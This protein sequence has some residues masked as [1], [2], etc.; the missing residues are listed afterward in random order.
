MSESALIWYFA[1]GSNMHA[2]TFRGRRGIEPLEARAARAP[3]WR[4]VLDKPPLLPIGESFANL[5]RDPD[6]EAL[7]VAYRIDDAAWQ[8]VCFTEGVAIGNYACVDL[9]CVA[10]GDGVQFLA[11]TLSS[12][13]RDAS[14][15]PSRRYMETLIAGAE[16]HGLP[17]AYVAHLRAQPAVEESA[18]ARRFRPLLDQV[19]RRG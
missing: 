15:L 18:D 9:E 1:Y 10:L 2:A 7:G 19:M 13:Q 17:A 8:H 3:G 5:I 16:E 12:E 11:T 4:V 6:G 14:L